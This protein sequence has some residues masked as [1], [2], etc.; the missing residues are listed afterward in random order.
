MPAVVQQSLWPFRCIRHVLS[1]K[2]TRCAWSFAFIEE[3]NSLGRPLHQ[4]TRV[5]GVSTVR[6]RWRWSMI[7]F[8]ND[9]ARITYLRRMNRISYGKKKHHNLLQ[10]D[11]NVFE[12]V[13][14]TSFRWFTRK[15]PFH[16]EHIYQIE[17]PSRQ[18][19]WNSA[20]TVNNFLRLCVLRQSIVRCGQLGE[21]R[22]CA[23]SLNSRT[24]VN[25][26]DSARRSIYRK[27]KHCTSVC[28]SWFYER[29]LGNSR[30][31]PV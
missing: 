18:S 12:I 19:S 7:T 26:N 30:K 5:R 29:L 6:I 25:L 17:I 3:A 1:I 23:V 15:L 20:N 10:W 2:C 16:S 9:Y 11:T 27:S 14:W 4:I 8:K 24:M 31:W 13:V 21:N 28:L 22:C